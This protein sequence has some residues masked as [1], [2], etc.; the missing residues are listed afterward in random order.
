M[1]TLLSITI[2]DEQGLHGQAAIDRAI[3][4]LQDRGITR[5]TRWGDR[6]ESF[7]AASS[8]VS[9]C[10]PSPKSIIVFWA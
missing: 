8:S 4:T 9:F 2:I 3:S 7:T 10:L 1:G 6:Q 5:S